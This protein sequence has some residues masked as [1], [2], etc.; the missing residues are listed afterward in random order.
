MGP[1]RWLLRASA[2][3]MD[4]ND[5]SEASPAVAPA[6]SEPANA[7][8]PAAIAIRLLGDDSTAASGI[9]SLVENRPARPAGEDLFLSF[10]QQP[11]AA[12]SLLETIRT[13]R[14]ERLGPVP[15]IPLESTVDFLRWN[16]S[17]D[18]RLPDLPGRRAPLEILTLPPHAPA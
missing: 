16:A 13:G 15:A 11:E 2:R 17:F 10:E 4:Y 1:P 6:V 5:G 3:I 9:R 14:E 12:A 7:V 18:H 8:D